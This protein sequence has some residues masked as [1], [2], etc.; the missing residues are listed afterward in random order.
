MGFWA[1]E[2]GAVTVDW[3]VLTASLVGLGLAVMALVSDGVEHQS[4]AIAAR[5]ATMG[6]PTS[7]ADFAAL[8]NG[9]FSYDPYDQ[10]I[11]DF[12]VAELSAMT[13]AELEIANAALNHGTMSAIE[14][15]EGRGDTVA[16]SDRE[17]VSDIYGALDTVYHERGLTRD[18]AARTYDQ[19]ALDAIGSDLFVPVPANATFD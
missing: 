9:G 11:F 7:F 13:D 14:A 3:V 8:R 5:A 12:V 10:Q 17:S 1:E 18:E 6:V 2:D 15:V 16:Q 19:A 4:D